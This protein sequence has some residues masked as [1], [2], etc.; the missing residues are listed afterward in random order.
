MKKVLLSLAIGLTAWGATA[1]NRYYV[2]PA[3][4]GAGDGTSWTDAFT[5]LNAAFTFH[6][7]SGSGYDTLW[8]AEGVYSPYVSAQTDKYDLTRTHNIYGG[9]VG[10]ETS[11]SQRDLANH[12]TIITGDVLGNDND[13][14]AFD[15]PT[16]SD[17]LESLLYIDP[18]V[19]YTTIDGV[20][21]EG[22]NS[23]AGQGN[24]VRFEQTGGT[25]AINMNNVVFRNNSMENGTMIYCHLGENYT[26][27]YV[28]TYTNCKFT[29]NAAG[30]LNYT[31]RA[32]RHSVEYTFI[33][34]LFAENHI[35]T[36][37]GTLI[38][39]EI[40]GQYPNVYRNVRL[41]NCTIV[42][43]TSL[44]GTGT[45]CIVGEYTY[46]QTPEHQ[47]QG[48]WIHNTI[49]QDNDFSHFASLLRTH[50]SVKMD[51][52]VVTNSF[53]EAELTDTIAYYYE[54]SGL[55]TTDQAGF[56]DVTNS[57]YRLS[58]CSPALNIGDATD[59][60]SFLPA[61]DLDGNAREY[62]TIDLGAYELN[63]A[64]QA[65]V[66]QA[67]ALMHVSQTSITANGGSG[68]TWFRNGEVISG[69]GASVLSVPGPGVYQVQVE[70]GN[71]CTA[72][73]GEFNTCN[74]GTI[75]IDVEGDTLITTSGFAQYEWLRNNLVIAGQTSDTAIAPWNA[76]GNIKVVVTD[77]YG[78]QATAE[79]EYC[80]PARNGQIFNQQTGLYII[81][82]PGEIYY[83]EDHG[84]FFNGIEFQWT[85]EGVPVPGETAYDYN[86]SP[87]T[88]GLYSCQVT[89]LSG[90]F[91]EV[92]YQL[93]AEITVGITQTGNMLDATAGFDSYQWYLD[94]VELVGEVGTSISPTAI[95]NYTVEV[96][97]GPCSETSA[98]YNYNMVGIQEAA[99]VSIAVYPN[100][101]TNVINLDLA[102]IQG[103]SEITM[104]DMAGRV[105]FT[106]IE[107]GT[108]VQLNLEHISDGAYTLMV[109]G[110]NGNTA[111]NRMIKN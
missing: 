98:A 76:N 32:K 3:A 55:N 69:A 2:N 67:S 52:L 92:F 30:N 111:M 13:N 95:G 23:L 110:E 37:G 59:L 53:I 19:Y 88:P 108:N 96:A 4:A 99:Q 21:F 16:R 33:N 106:S 91:V 41:I 89:Y 46:I 35:T 6:N 68:F 31:I 63:S 28:N 79:I 65:T 27:A 86:F 72:M 77:V 75:N 17:N 29:N 70:Y 40:S 85:Y 45:V 82:E 109:R 20:V 93:C 57:D 11:L 22:A 39:A 87:M 97:D 50:N 64:A 5:S 43:N 74:V 7:A 49:E 84:L 103:Q 51:T 48:L 94:G 34:T 100:P 71:G 90:C 25:Y 62:G 38:R 47:E 104:M 105:V 101:F 10:T 107:I 18:S 83:A 80:A 44:S 58:T 1:Q 24:V 54:E 81:S 12:T 66:T 73:S 102:D 42:K 60:A 78:C 8:V 36:S 61:I 56:V 15:E 14:I 9:F 26:G